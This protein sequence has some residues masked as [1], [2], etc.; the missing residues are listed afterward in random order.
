MFDLHCPWHPHLHQHLRECKCLKSSALSPPFLP[1]NAEHVCNNE[2]TVNSCLF[3]H[4]Q[5][6]SVNLRL[7]S[8][9]ITMNANRSVYKQPR[10]HVFHLFDIKLAQSVAHNHLS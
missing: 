7:F 6:M 9:K 5:T 3:S 2:T 8:Q 10:L 1:L 4:T